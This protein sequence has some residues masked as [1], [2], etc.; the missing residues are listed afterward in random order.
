MMRFHPDPVVKWRSDQAAS[1]PEPMQ[2]ISG[3]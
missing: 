1:P 3:L 2:W